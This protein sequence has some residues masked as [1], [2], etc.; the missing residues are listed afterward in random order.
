[1]H[2]YGVNKQVCVQRSGMN[3]RCKHISKNRSFVHREGV[4]R[5]VG[6]QREQVRCEQVRTG[7]MYTDKV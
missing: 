1:M 7:H 5:L 6:L 3:V 2:K 4:N